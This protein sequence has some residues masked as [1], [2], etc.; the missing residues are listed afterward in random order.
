MIAQ[1]TVQG[2]TIGPHPGAGFGISDPRWVGLEVNAPDY[3]EI[4]PNA[5]RRKRT[6]VVGT[7]TSRSFSARAVLSRREVRR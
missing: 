5:R 4:D 3:F 7:A 6:D 2:R 1:L